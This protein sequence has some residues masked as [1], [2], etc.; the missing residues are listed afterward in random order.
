LVKKD[1]PMHSPFSLNELLQSL[2][3]NLSLLAMSR[4]VRIEIV[5]Q[6]GSCSIVADRLQIFRALQNV[7]V[8]AIEA[9]PKALGKV[10][11]AYGSVDHQVEIIVADNGCGIDPRDAKHLFEPLFTTKKTKGTGLGLYITR[12]V[13]EDHRGSLEVRS[14]PGCGTSVVIRLPLV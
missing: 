7:L 8:N 10:R 9:S 3:K 12:K 13:I 14:K 1:A 5:A 2:A 6:E 4:G 11:I